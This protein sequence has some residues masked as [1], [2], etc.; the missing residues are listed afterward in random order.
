[1][2]GA[3]ARG[4][5]A[6]LHGA[7]ARG[8]LAPLHGADARGRLAPLHGADAR[9]RLAPL[10]GADARFSLAPLHGADARF[11]LAPLHGADARGRLAWGSGQRRAGQGR[12]FAAYAISKFVWVGFSARLKSGPDTQRAQGGRTILGDKS[13]RLQKAR[14]YSGFRIAV[15]KG[16][17][18]KSTRPQ[19]A[20]TS[21]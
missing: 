20:A 8:R 17:T 10:H 21:Q 16:N 12:G 5:L 4:R 1:L 13:C 18:L 2:H 7:D 19:G 9:V 11:S 15:P 14:G 6:P 3:D